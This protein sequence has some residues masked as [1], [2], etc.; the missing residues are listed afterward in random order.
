MFVRGLPRSMSPRSRLL[1]YNPTRWRVIIGVFSPPPLLVSVPIG[2][3]LARGGMQASWT[4]LTNQRQDI[5]GGKPL[6]LKLFKIKRR[7]RARREVKVF[8][9]SYILWFEYTVFSGDV[10]FRKYITEVLYL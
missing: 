8:F 7:L 2:Q 10:I 5:R 4:A 9:Y 1:L 6:P 3:A